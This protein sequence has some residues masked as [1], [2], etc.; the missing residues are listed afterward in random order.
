MKTITTGSK[1][2][3]QW[4]LWKQLE[5]LDFADD[6]ASL[7]H[8]HKQM[9]DKT[10]KLATT[11]L[12]TGLRINKE[13]TK[14]MRI[15]TPTTNPVNID[16]RPIQEVDS[17]TYLGSPI[18][19][20]GGTDSDV[21]ARVGKARV[22]FI[23]LKNIWASKEIATSTKVRIFNTN[24]KSILLYGSETWRMTKKTLQKI[25][26]FINTCLSRIFRIRWP[27]KINNKELWERGSQ[28]P[29]AEQILRRKWGWIG[30]TLRKPADSIT[31]QALTWNPQGKRKRGRP[32][33]TW[34]R[35]TEAELKRLGSSWGGA[36][37]RAQS[38]AEW[39][40]VVDGLCSR[41]EQRAL[42]R[43][44]VCVKKI[45]VCCTVIADA[46]I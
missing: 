46:L 22:A 43:H 32:R 30:H 28:E 17:F 26:T 38:R 16:D 2:G 45:C 23:I 25:Q 12:G 5:D 41:P 42:R 10:T 18:D 20:Q 4:T 7:S 3:I 1:T 33:N 36:E 15:N 37:K 19:H 29:V 40:V 34:R 24:V 9:Q 14:L 27:D 13:K 44:D 21:L 39:R 11:S 6:L 35:D 8:N 31:R